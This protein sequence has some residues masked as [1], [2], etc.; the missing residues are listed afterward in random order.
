[1]TGYITLL[2]DAVIIYIVIIMFYQPFLWTKFNEKLLK[3]STRDGGINLCEVA[4]VE[5]QLCQ[6]QT[7]M[8]QDTNPKQVIKETLDDNHLLLLAQQHNSI[9]LD[10]ENQILPCMSGKL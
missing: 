3:Y 6:I 7:A 1:M 2:L 9:V 4:M 8:S 5:P 10:R